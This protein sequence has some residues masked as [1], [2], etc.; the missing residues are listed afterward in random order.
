MAITTAQ[1]GPLL[2]PGINALFMME[3]DKHSPEY[4]QV[5]ET[6]S[7]ERAWEEDQAMPGFG[8]APAK[9]EGQGVSYDQFQTAW[10][11]YYRMVTYGL[12]FSITEEAVDDNLYGSLLTKGASALAFSMNETKETVGASILNNGFSSSY[13]GGDGKPFLATDHPKTGGGSFSNILATPADLSETALEDLQTQIGAATTDRGLNIRLL[14]KKL[15]VPNGLQWTA[16]RILGSPGRVGTGDNDI[17][18]HKGEMPIVT[19]HRLTD[20]DAWFIK[21]NCPDGMKHFSRK[22]LRTKMEGEFETGNVRY[23]A[24]ER[25]AFGWTDVR[26][27]Y[28]SAG[29]A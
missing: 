8:L 6:L 16:Q 10:K 11:A 27:C 15:I 12:A 7:S 20:D 13:V 28:A 5:F 19:M 26:S 4:T 2:E 21:T 25:Y 1:I 14:G 23:K 9:S 17:N 3:Y 22:K 29:A 18:V 24:I